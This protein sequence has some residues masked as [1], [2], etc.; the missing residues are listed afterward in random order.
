VN[1]PLALAK[2]KE[3]KMG[4]YMYPPLPLYLEEVVKT[5]CWVTQANSQR[6]PIPLVCL[7]WEA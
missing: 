2:E 7:E 5:S 3:T 4:F 1:L 6:D